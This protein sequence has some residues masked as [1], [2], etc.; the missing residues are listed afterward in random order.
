MHR[1]ESPT[2][3]GAIKQLILDRHLGPGDAMPTENELVEL[4]G[5]S[6]SSVREAVRTLVALDILE[7]RH[8]RGTFVGGVSLRPLVE[9]LVFRGVMSSPDD[10]RAL[11]EVVE[12]RTTLDL[13]MAERVLAGFDGRD[14]PA[15]REL[16]D[17][18][19]EAAARGDNFTEADQ[20][21]HVGLAALQHNQ[22]FGQMVGALWEIHATT[23]PRLGLPTTRDLED[24]ARAHVRLLDRAVAGDLEGYRQAVVEHYEPLLRVLDKA[25]P[26]GGVKEA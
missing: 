1:P 22:L 5:V 24:T 12:L 14:E 9:G 21:F 10:Y 15:L 26:A 4:L 13:A 11:R 8:G 25:Y 23:A 2:P 3:T 20:A 7:V 19:L 16:T 17:R 6:R 18:M